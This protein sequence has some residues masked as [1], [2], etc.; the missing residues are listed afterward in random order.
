MLSKHLTSSLPF[1]FVIWKLG[2][3]NAAIALGP[4]GT[5]GPLAT[6]GAAGTLV[7][8]SGDTY[9]SRTGRTS[10]YPFF[11]RGIGAAIVSLSGV[12]RRFRSVTR[13]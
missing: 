8:A 3:I 12:V 7:A 5:P 13:V 1:M 4:S 6:A 10:P 11:C 9:S 2:G